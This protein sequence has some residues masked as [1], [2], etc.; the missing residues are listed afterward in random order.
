MMLGNQWAKLQFTICMLKGLFE[1]GRRSP[2]G[3]LV[4]LDGI[5]SGKG[6]VSNISPQIIESYQTQYAIA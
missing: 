6:V 4:N 2:G 3:V 1:Y 5:R